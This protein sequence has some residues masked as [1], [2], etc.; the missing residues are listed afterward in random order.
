MAPEIQGALINVH[1]PSPMPTGAWVN[2]KGQGSELKA[3]IPSFLRPRDQDAAPWPTVQ[4]PAT[5]EELPSRAPE[6]NPVENIWQNMRAN[7][8]SNRVHETYVAIIE[9]VCEA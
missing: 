6:L 8:V 5:V 2:S 3:P 7:W 4:S 9:A 1:G